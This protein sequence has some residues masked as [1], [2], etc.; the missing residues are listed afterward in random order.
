[1]HIQLLE[2][3]VQMRMQGGRCHFQSTGNFLVGELAAPSGELQLPALGPGLPK[4]VAQNR[5]RN[6]GLP[7]QLSNAAFGRLGVLANW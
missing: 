6:V 1:M 5:N 3:V 4:S 2:D 7:G